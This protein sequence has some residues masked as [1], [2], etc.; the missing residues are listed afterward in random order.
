[1][2]EC[3]SALSTTLLYQPWSAFSEISISRKYPKLIFS[4]EV[5]QKTES[6]ATVFY[7]KP[8]AK[9]KNREWHNFARCK[10]HLD[11]RNLN[12]IF[13]IAL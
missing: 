7:D 6:L 8:P 1:M 9:Q 10:I 3:V 4:L 11:I 2:L 5:F 12:T 13:R